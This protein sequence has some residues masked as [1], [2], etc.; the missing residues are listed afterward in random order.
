MVKWPRKIR[1][2]S[3]AKGLNSFAPLMLSEKWKW[4]RL[5]S[6][7]L[8]GKTIFEVCTATSFSR[9]FFDEGFQM[10]F[11]LVKELRLTRCDVSELSTVFRSL[12]QS[13]WRWCWRLRSFSC[14]STLLLLLQCQRQ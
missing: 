11:E 3:L 6:M 9:G 13:S 12:K 1:V 5:N 4:L 10:F 14:L 2:S 8:D 7:M